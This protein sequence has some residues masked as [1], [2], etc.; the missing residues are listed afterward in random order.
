[1]EPSKKHSRD[2]LLIASTEPL[3]YPFPK[4]VLN[5]ENWHR[6]SKH[7]HAIIYVKT[8]LQRPKALKGQP[9]WANKYLLLRRNLAP[10]PE[11]VRVR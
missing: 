5:N 4:G 2:S 3:A 7:D 10:C 9:A 1:M 6:R 8:D 11:H